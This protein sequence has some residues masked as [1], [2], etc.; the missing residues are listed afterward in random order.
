MKKNYVLGLALSAIMLL[1]ACGGGAKAPDKNEADTKEETKVEETAQ[2]DNGENEESAITNSN[3]LSDKRVRQALWYAID[4]DSIANDIW[5]GQVTAANKS[6]VP[7]GDRQAD[8]LIE[9]KYDP[10]KAKELL[11]EANWDPNYKLKAVYYTENLL[12]TITAIQAYWQTVGV[13]MEFQLLKDN[14][15]AQLWTPPADKENGPSEVDWDICFAGTNA[16]TLSEF[17]TRYS[18]DAANNS[19]VPY[20]EENENLIMNIKTAVTPEEQKKAYD[21]MQ[22]FQNEEVY[23]MPMFYIPSWIITSDKLDMAGDPVGNDQFNYEKNI[24]DWKIDRD[25]NTM[26]TNSGAINSLENP[27]TNPGLYWHQELVFDRLIQANPDLT[28]SEEGQLAEGYEVQDDGKTYVFNLHEGVKWHDG[29]PF[30]GEDVKWTLEY[31]PTVTG[32][33]AIMQEVYADINEINVDGS[34]VT[35]KFNNVQPNALTVFSQWPILP[36]HLLEKVDP[37]LF[38]ADKFWQK[39]IG[40]GPFKVAEVELGD[41]TTLERNNDYFVK[42]EGNIEKIYLYPSDD[43][44]DSNLVTNVNAGKIDYAFCKDATQIE[45]LEGVDGYNVERI[46]VTF[47]RYAFFNM[48]PRKDK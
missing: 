35:V 37:N 12:D 18:K 44:G 27:A 9:Y 29:E 25:D 39:P 33:N 32:A 15:T 28:P 7:E 8:D 1:T 36:K 4:M 47:P 38:A 13:N 21:D 42:G 6:L 41:H 43:S 16:L 31:L 46:E 23:T 48:F 5:S 2:T 3:P 11:K 17:Y 19:T 20:N 45:Q 26:Y 34:T 22:K 10:E 40:T 14:L 24:V 30:T